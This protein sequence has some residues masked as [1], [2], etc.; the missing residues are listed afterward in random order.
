M[1]VARVNRATK[2]KLTASRFKAVATGVPEIIF[3]RS[4]KFYTYNM[5]QYDV[6]SFVGFATSWYTKGELIFIC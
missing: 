1:N 6:Q 4:G 5:K 2:G 3:L